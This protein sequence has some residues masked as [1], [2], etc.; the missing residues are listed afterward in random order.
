[1]R[2]ERG[3]IYIE[4]VDN[5]GKD[6]VSQIIAQDLHITN[7]Q[8]SILV[9]SNPYKKIR[10]DDPLFGLYIARS[11][12]YDLKHWNP[13]TVQQLQVSFNGVRSAV[14]E[15]GQPSGL[16]PVFQELLK[17]TPRFD[18]SFLLTASVEAR[19]ERVANRTDAVDYDRLI[20]TDPAR[21]ARMDTAMLDSASRVLGATIVDTTHLN[22][23]EV[24]LTIEN[25]VSSMQDQDKVT[26]VRISERNV[27]PEEEYIEKE[28]G[29]YH[30]YLIRKQL[31]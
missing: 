24:A 31:T 28:L 4:G 29:H 19:K 7:I 26:A 9:P 6:T 10:F 20:I 18:N 27:R 23:K 11:I 25:M 15:A 2:Q 5:V 30:D 16:A 22:P 3:H 21:A 17:Y 14:H 12:I 8:R 13:L 1:M